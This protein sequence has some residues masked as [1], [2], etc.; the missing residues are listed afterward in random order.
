MNS[1]AICVSTMQIGQFS[2]FSVSCALGHSPWTTYDMAANDLSTCLNISNK[3]VAFG[4][5]FSKPGS[6]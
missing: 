5:T 3:N 1:G 6:V 2:T 4:N